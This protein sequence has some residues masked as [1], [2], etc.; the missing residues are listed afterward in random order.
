MIQ[1]INQ[2]SDSLSELFCANITFPL[3]TETESRINVGIAWERIEELRIYNKLSRFSPRRFRNRIVI[4]ILSK[5]IAQF[6]DGSYV[7]YSEYVRQLILDSGIYEDN[8]ALESRLG[9]GMTRYAARYFGED[10]PDNKR[11]IGAGS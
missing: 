4:R 9:L 3:H 10:D 1:V 2:I 5:L 8:H 6:S 11:W 7:R